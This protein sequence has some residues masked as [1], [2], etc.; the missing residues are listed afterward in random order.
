MTFN[1]NNIR[2]GWVTAGFS[3]RQI[4]KKYIFACYENL[5]GIMDVWRNE[6]DNLGFNY[7]S[8]NNG[9]LVILFPYDKKWKI[10]IDDKPVEFY[11]ANY[12]FMS[13]PIT[14]G[15]HKVLIQYWPDT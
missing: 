8:R 3:K 12:S 2:K 5:S 9:W 15:K 13:L 6:G 14:E 4:N 10:M 1:V 7:V 11:R